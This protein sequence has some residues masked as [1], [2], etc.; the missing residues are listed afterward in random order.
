[1]LLVIANEFQSLPDSFKCHSF[2]F[3]KIL[4]DIVTSLIESGDTLAYAGYHVLYPL[5]QLVENAESARSSCIDLPDN[6]SI[7][8]ATIINIVS[9]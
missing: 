3:F 4:L 5:F 9:E 2:P 7:C 1:M 6:V 8:G